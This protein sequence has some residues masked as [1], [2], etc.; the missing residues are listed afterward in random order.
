MWT[1]IGIIWLR[2]YYQLS[3]ALFYL[4]ET[5]HHLWNQV[6]SFLTLWLYTSQAL[7][8]MT[9]R[10]YLFIMMLEYV[11]VSG[12]FLLNQRSTSTCIRAFRCRVWYSGSIEGWL[13]ICEK[14]AQFTGQ[15]SHI[16]WIVNCYYSDN[17]HP[18]HSFAGRWMDMNSNII[19]VFALLPCMVMTTL[20]FVAMLYILE[21]WWLPVNLHIW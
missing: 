20:T 2:D 4:L 5:K 15:L 3:G 16:W 14:F 19:R 1:I 10:Q 13:D 21:N 12:W 17:I 9:E 11:N 7:T 18:E 8:D 6:D